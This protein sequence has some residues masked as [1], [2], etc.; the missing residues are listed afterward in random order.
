M[1]LLKVKRL[2]PDPK[3]ALTIAP[4]GVVFQVKHFLTAPP[5]TCLFA[6]F[7]LCF[8][9]LENG[10]GKEK[11]L[12][13]SV[14]FLVLGSRTSLQKNS[15]AKCP[16]PISEHQSRSPSYHHIISLR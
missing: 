14:S 3:L 11:L 2:Y 5:Q 8:D 16:T 4:R 10:A 7:A 15:K 13:K 1:K 12:E 6:G 9:E